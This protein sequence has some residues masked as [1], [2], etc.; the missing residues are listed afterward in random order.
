M[1]ILYEPIMDYTYN[2]SEEGVK[3]IETAIM[4]LEHVTVIG[5]PEDY[6]Y[7]HSAYFNAINHLNYENGLKH[8]EKILDN[9]EK[10][11]NGVSAD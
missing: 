5:R 1:Y 7:P 6:V 11:V 4:E 3:M 2:Q 10:T 9:Y 8:T